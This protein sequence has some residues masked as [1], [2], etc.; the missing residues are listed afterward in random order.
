MIALE[1]SIR[2]NFAKL[3]GKRPEPQP[4]VDQVKSIDIRLQLVPYLSS[5]T[6]NYQ[7]LAY[8][9]LNQRHQNP[10]VFPD[11]E[12]I[13][14]GYRLLFGAFD[15][16]AHLHGAILLNRDN[17]IVHHW[18]FD[19]VEIKKFFENTEVNNSIR[20]PEPENRWPHGVEVFSDGS[21][22]ANLGNGDAGMLKLDS[23]SNIQWMQKGSFHDV[24]QS[25]GAGNVWS[26]N[27]ETLIVLDQDSGQVQKEI[28]LNDIHL[29]NPELA[30]L[31]PRRSLRT[32]KWY[33][34]PVH[35]ADVEPLPENL[36][37]KFPLFH[38]GDLLISYR[39][40]NLIVVIDPLTLKI[41]WWRTGV[42]Q[43]QGD[44]DWEPDGTIS[45]Y[46]NNKRDRRPDWDGADTDSEQN[47]RF[48]RIVKIDPMTMKFTEV[49]NGRSDKFY[50]SDFGKHQILP[51]GNI[52]IS[53]PEQGRVF[54]INQFGEISFEFLNQYDENQSLIIS[55]GIWLPED[56]FSE[57]FIR[58]ANCR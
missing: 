31:T 12:N 43:R 50:S 25:D 46:D 34:D 24:V 39:S 45:I 26:L 29:A 30:V 33:H 54:E 48:S 57:A 17:N 38:Q 6:R 20:I 36:A 9:D 15:F 16:Q 14:E 19:E 8:D 32:S 56:Y 10:V 42:S 53:S 52:L 35:S 21:I 5:I 55:Q 13:T 7:S 58:A 44:V 11:A 23:C 3:F 40:L 47:T 1:T 41:K 2:G 51:N 27:N 49:Y 22:V 18:E 4:A 28:G 37:D